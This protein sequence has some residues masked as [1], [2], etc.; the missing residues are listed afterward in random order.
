MR[1]LAV[2]GSGL[3]FA[4]LLS[5]NSMFGLVSPAPFLTLP[6]RYAPHRWSGSSTYQAPRVTTQHSRNGKRERQRRMCQIDSGRLTVA[7]GL[8]S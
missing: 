6:A 2:T 3:R 5:F 7:N 8:V 4:S 1:G